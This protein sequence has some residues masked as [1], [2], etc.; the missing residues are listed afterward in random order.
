M[1]ESVEITGLDRN[2]PSHCLL[3]LPSPAV[4]DGDQLRAELLAAHPELEELSLLCYSDEGE[5]Q[6]SFPL[7][8]PRGASATDKRE[9]TN[10]QKEIR[11]AGDRVESARL[12]RQAAIDAKV[13]EARQLQSD[14]ATAT[15]KVQREWSALAEVESRPEAEDDAGKEHRRQIT[16]ERRVA[17]RRAHE[18]AD[19][20]R[21]QIVAADIELR[22]ISQ[23]EQVITERLD[24]FTSA[25]RRAVE[26][27][28]GWTEPLA[29]IVA[30]HRPTKGDQP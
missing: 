3:R 1:S 5:V 25:R 27:Q 11:Q 21:G 16:E 14:A 10:V 30:Q 6:I 17:M 20:L 9:W 4:F 19:A 2:R 18:E 28:S 26:I 7:T 24:R 22:R 29:H 12:E 15:H 8:M 23:D 13:L